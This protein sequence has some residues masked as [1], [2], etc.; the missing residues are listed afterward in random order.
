M[1]QD[2]WRCGGGGG[3]QKEKVMRVWSARGRG[4]DQDVLVVRE[5]SLVRQYIVDHTSAATIRNHGS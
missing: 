3:P 1:E 2:Q 5:K 4:G